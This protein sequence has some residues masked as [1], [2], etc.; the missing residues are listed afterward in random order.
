M[1]SSSLW[2]HGNVDW[3]KTDNFCSIKGQCIVLSRAGEGHLEANGLSEVSHY[4]SLALAPSIPF[5]PSFSVCCHACKWL[6]AS[7]TL[8]M[9]L[10]ECKGPINQVGFSSTARSRRCH[11]A[12]LIAYYSDLIPAPSPSLWRSQ[13]YECTSY[14]CCH[15]P[16]ARDVIETNRQAWIRDL[17][18]SHGGQKRR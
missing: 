3:N 11:S 5:F 8:K 17:R 16:H 1:E 6:Q 13:A 18:C 14:C 9:A 15:G 12:L 10:L 7:E 4:P 2:C